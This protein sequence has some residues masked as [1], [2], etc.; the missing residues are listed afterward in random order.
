MNDQV[1]EEKSEKFLK[2]VWSIIRKPSARY[3]LGT[4]IAVGFVSGIVFWGSFNWSM[5]LTNNEEFCISC[6]EMEQNVYR[7]YKR[8]V[9]YSNRS[10]VR[11]TCPDCHVPKTWIHKIA[12]KI[13]ASNEL[14]HHFLGTIDT[15]EKYEAKRLQLA[16]NEWR[17]MKETDSR[18]CRNCHNFEYMDFTIQE[19]RSRKRHAEAIDTGKTCIDCHKGIAHELPEGAF[20]AE[21][22]MSK[23]EV[24]K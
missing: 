14:Y 24:S 17:R 2:R 3:T 21:K 8:T 19:N 12:R 9:H 11:A 18:E 15:R 1:P 5:E 13:Q 22:E 10:G 6:H 16:K 4:L 23:T 20:E 7:E